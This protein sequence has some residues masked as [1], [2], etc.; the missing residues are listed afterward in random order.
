[1][2]PN[3]TEPIGLA[4]RLV[5]LVHNDIGEYKPQSAEQDAAAHARWAIVLERAGLLIQQEI[6]RG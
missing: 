1:M 5:E 4:L 6:R 2:K 3:T